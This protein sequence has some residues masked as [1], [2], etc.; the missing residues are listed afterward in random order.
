MSASCAA[1]ATAVI[2]FFVYVFVISC[3]LHEKRAK[4][5]RNRVERTPETENESE[6]NR[7]RERVRREKTHR[8]FMKRFK[9]AIY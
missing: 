3:E 6:K 5:W 4:W 2:F 8:T 1:A 7:E 9:F